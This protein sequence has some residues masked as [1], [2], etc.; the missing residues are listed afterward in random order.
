MVFAEFDRPL[1][2]VP[3]QAIQHGLAA[4]EFHRMALTVGVPDSFDVSITIQRPCESSGGV[5]ASRKKDQSF[6]VHGD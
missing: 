4:L 6:G 5:L 3:A 1:G 2:K